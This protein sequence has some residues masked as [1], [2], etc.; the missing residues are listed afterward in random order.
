MNTINWGRSLG[1]NRKIINT[2]AKKLAREWM[3]KY[4]E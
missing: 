1:A 3:E 2:Q 4:N